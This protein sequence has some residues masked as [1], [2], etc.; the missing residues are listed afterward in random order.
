MTMRRLIIALGGLLAVTLMGTLGYMLLGFTLLEAMYQTITTLATVG[1]R[2]V[3]PM[4]P[5][6]MVFT[7]FLIVSGVGV[8]LYNLGVLLETLSEGHIRGAIA[9]RSMNRRIFRMRG[10]VIVV[11]HGRVA[12]AAIEQLR[13]TRHEVVVIDIDPER[14]ENAGVEHII[15]DGTDDNVLRQAGIAH[16]RA[17]IACVDTDAATVYVTLSARALRKDLVIIARARSADSKEKLLL[18]GATRAIN[19]QMSGGRRIAAFALHPDVAEFLDMVRPG[20]E[21]DQWIQQVQVLAR[22]RVVGRTL[23]ELRLGE[24]TGALMLAIRDDPGVDF[25]LNP[26]QHTKVGPDAVLIA[27][28][29]RSQ[30]HAL[31]SICRH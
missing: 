20:E 7:M 15:G 24:R 25:L 16:A 12:R 28:G 6:G 18:A 30:I 29:T 13:A 19:P 2:E 31:E 9:R 4:G 3:K 22:S 1:F 27:L 21:F 14:V 23:G 11:G 17:L 10:H 26:P 5:V 8:V